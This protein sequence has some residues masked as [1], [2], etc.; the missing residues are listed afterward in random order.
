MAS[1]AKKITSLDRIKSKALRIALS[2]FRQDPELG[3][4][5]A[6]PVFAEIVRHLKAG[7]SEE[8]IIEEIIR[9]RSRT[10]TTTLSL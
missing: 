3:T 2:A 9:K 4:R 1:K 8:G 10:T 6:K 7:M 5:E